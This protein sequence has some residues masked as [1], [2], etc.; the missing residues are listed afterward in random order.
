MRGINSLIVLFLGVHY[1]E[2][3]LLVELQSFVITHL[4]MPAGKIHQIRQYVLGTLPPGH[5]QIVG[6]I[7]QIRQYVLG[8]LPPGHSQIVGK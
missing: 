4:N 2:A 8:T 5:S 6:K 3:R 1:A 7:H